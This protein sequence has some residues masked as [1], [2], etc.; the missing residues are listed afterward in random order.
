[1]GNLDKQEDKS[2]FK[3]LSE[4]LITACILTLTSFIVNKLLRIT[5]G[6]ITKKSNKDLIR[7]NKVKEKH[8]ELTKDRRKAL[9]KEFREWLVNRGEDI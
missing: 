4:T 2:L 5:N 3:A 7:Y 8:A 9:S 1:M 6:L